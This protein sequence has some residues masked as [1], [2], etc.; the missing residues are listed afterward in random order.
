M[1]KLCDIK[2]DLVKEDMEFYSLD[3]LRRITA[4]N[5]TKIL[6]FSPQ[7]KFSDVLDVGVLEDGRLQIKVPKDISQIGTIKL[8]GY[9]RFFFSLE[10]EHFNQKVNKLKDIDF[11]KTGI[12]EMLEK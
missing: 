6:S 7:V 9:L 8:L 1:K 10:K 5:L 4:E 2:P 12:K 11:N 3:T